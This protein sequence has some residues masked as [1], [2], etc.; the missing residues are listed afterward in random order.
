MKQSK[1]LIPTIHENS[2]DTGESEYSLL[3]R[4]GFV[5]KTLGG[6]T[7]YLPLAHRVLQKIKEIIR[8]ELRKI[9]A[10]EITMPIVYPASEKQVEDVS[11]ALFLELVQQTITTCDQL[12]VN[13]FHMP[14]R[15]EHKA[16][17]TLETLISESFSFQVTSENQEEIFR[18]YET[19][20]STILTRC[21]IAFK[22]VL[23]S[24]KWFSQDAKEFVAL[25]EK[26][27]QS[28]VVSTE[29]DYAADSDLATSL[30]TSKKSHATYLERE[31]VAT[32]V[33]RSL[34]DVAQ[35]LDVTIQRMLQTYLYMVEERPTLL[36]MRG[37]HQLN[38]RKV[39]NFLQ[40]TDIRPATEEDAQVHLHV[41]LSE[42]SPVDTQLAVY[43]DSYVEDLVNVVATA[44][45]EGFHY[46]NVNP[47]RDFKPLAYFDFRQVE[48]GDLSP[49]GEGSLIFSKAINIGEIIKINASEMQQHGFAVCSEEKQDF[50]V[51]MGYY[52][53]NVSQLLTAI[54]EQHSKE[55]GLVWPKAIAPFD[56][57]ILQLDMS[58][59]YQTTLVNEV[60]E[61]MTEV[62]HEVLIDDR[63]E[64][65][66]M[67]RMDANFIGCPICITVG[68]KAVDGVV[69][70]KIQKSE[71]LIEVRKEELASTLEI[72]MHEE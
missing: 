7:I 19:A 12:P 63:K 36:V 18:K 10:V 34:Q 33:Q 44:N 51:S 46:L 72:L 16:E 35:Y 13:V 62:G 59:D 27:D 20:Y 47:N 4:A 39:Q 37:D 54:I 32:P 40:T 61:A 9:D 68:T 66:E 30:Y 58:D 22:S 21:E 65:E 57:H 6:Q 69:E 60:F 17:G 43:A 64:T 1:L 42:V 70:V 15:V 26:G 23:S 55:T 53:F 2:A 31:K 48:A 56:V 28:I 41:N 3:Q 52:H 29:S 49:D 50:P 5:R 8:E 25:S 11:E 71:A 14:R 45:E 24:N 38:L 67:K